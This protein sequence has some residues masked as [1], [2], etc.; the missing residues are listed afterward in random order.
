MKHLRLF[1][2]A[3][4]GLSIS[5][6]ASYYAAGT[7]IPMIHEKGDLQVAAGATVPILNADA[8]V[9][10]GITD[11]LAAQ[12]YGR[13][14]NDMFGHGAIG[15]YF[16]MQHH[17][18]SETYGGFGYGYD[19][20]DSSDSDGDGNY[21]WHENHFQD[22]FIQTNFGQYGVGRI[23]ADYGISLK[24]SILKMNDKEHKEHDTPL[25]FYTLNQYPVFALEPSLFAHFGGEHL[26]FG[27]RL[28]Y[29]ELFYD[30]DTYQLVHWPLNG[31]VSLS[32]RF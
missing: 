8:T 27:I 21:R 31:S 16:P 30:E 22:Y 25:E 12:V 28:G 23:N 1:L 2:L 4:T 9:S 19:R 24:G 26:R 15:V 3:L 29:S 5:G 32:Y 6:C 7:D 10:Y 11:H 17:L 13:F 14:G 18:L 20:E